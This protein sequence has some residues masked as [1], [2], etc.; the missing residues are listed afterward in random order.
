MLKLMRY[1]RGRG[2]PLVRRAFLGLLAGGV[3]TTSLA[4]AQ[5]SSP[6]TTLVVLVDGSKNPELISDDLALRHFLLAVA[7]HEQPSQAES[8]RQDAQLTPL[9]LSGP[10]RQELTRQLGLMTTQL[11]ALEAESDGSGASPSDV[12]ARRNSL[13]AQ[14]AASVRKALSADGWAR[15]NSYVTQSVKKKVKIYGLATK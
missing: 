11:E 2:W 1:Q 12:R 15:L 5:A 7:A 10:D 8:D 6:S 3:V 4:G 14:T 13:I 9:G